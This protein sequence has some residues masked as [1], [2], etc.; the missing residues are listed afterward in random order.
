MILFG[1][2]SLKLQS[3]LSD[4]SKP[5]LAEESQSA[6]RIFWY[7]RYWQQSHAR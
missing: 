4:E 3:R 2:G 1:I 6:M 5:G 7:Q